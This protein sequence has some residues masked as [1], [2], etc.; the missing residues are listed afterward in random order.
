MLRQTCTRMGHPA[1]VLGWRRNTGRAGWEPSASLALGPQQPL[2]TAR[3]GAG[4]ILLAEPVPPGGSVT[5]RFDVVAPLLPGTAP[6]AWQMLFDEHPFGDLLTR[7]VSV[8]PA[9]RRRQP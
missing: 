2:D 9:P 7:D 3:W 8:R 5:Y 6:F 4:R 1:A